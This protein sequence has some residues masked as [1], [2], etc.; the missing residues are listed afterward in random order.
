M[1]KEHTIKRL[2]TEGLFE[3][4]NEKLGTKHIVDIHK[5]DCKGDVCNWQFLKKSK[6][7]MRNACQHILLAKGI[8]EIKLR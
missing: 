2:E 1:T 7:T 3:V 8:K 6:K 4:V 5:P